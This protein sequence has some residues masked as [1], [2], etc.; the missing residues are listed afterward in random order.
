MKAQVTK[1]TESELLKSYPIKGNVSG[2]YYRTIETSNNAWLVEGS[3][4]WG[5]KLSIRGND[6]DV[7]IQKAE[8]QASEINGQRKN[9]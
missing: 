7:L 3:D 8:E 5:R 4:C 9:T 6:P 2:W 1:L